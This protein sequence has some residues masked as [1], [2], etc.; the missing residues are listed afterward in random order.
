MACPVPSLRI[1]RDELV[2]GN[3]E[4]DVNVKAIAEESDDECAKWKQ[5]PL[6]LLR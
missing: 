1:Q 2:L 6:F 5:P 3:P 4:I